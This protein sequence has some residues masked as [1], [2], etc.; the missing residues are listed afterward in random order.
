MTHDLFSRRE[1]AIFQTLDAIKECEFVVIGG[2]AVNAYAL[3]RFSVDCDIVIKNNTELKRIV[4]ILETIDY[5]RVTSTDDVPYSG[6]FARYEKVLA[7]DFRV[8]ID[9][10]IGRVIDRQTN[11]TFD[12]EWVFAHASKKLLKGKTIQQNMMLH[13]IDIDALLVMKIIAARAT[14]IRDVFMMLPAAS[15][16]KWVRAEIA[17]RCDANERIGVVAAKVNASQFKDGLAGVYGRVDAKLFEK[18]KKAILE[19]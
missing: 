17:L 14:D 4:K 2:Y 10:L 5:T 3:P 18:H 6:N 13:I 19:F 8:S 15:D 12:A 11:A 16:K 7:Q 1:E 9:I